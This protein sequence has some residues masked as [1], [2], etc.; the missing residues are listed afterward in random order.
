MGKRHSHETVIA[1]VVSFGTAA[2]IGAADGFCPLCSGVVE[3]LPHIFVDC[4][5]ARA[6]WLGCGAAFP[7]CIGLSIGCLI[8]LIGA[9]PP[10]NAKSSQ[11]FFLLHQVLWSLWTG[12]IEQFFGSEGSRCFDFFV[13]HAETTHHL[14]AVMINALSDRIG[15]S[16]SVAG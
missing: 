7:G 8:E 6:F 13:L 14:L 16:S 2:K 11:G 5:H 9:L 1:K 12:R 15:T 10:K 4:P 3:S